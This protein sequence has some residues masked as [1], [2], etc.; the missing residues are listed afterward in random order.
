M[1]NILNRYSYS[2][3]EELG[4]GAFGRVYKGVDSKTNKPVAIKSTHNLNF[5]YEFRWFI[6]LIDD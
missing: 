5:S 6:R 1:K 4:R 2:E 3:N